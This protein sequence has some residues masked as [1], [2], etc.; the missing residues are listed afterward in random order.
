M[1]IFMM[2]IKNEL[3][4][5]LKLFLLLNYPHEKYKVYGIWSE[6]ETHKKNPLAA[7]SQ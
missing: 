2:I 4:I 3:F 5:M 1:L 6:P 7:R